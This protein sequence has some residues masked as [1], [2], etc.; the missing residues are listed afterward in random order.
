MTQTNSLGVIAEIRH[1][2]THAE[3]G[4]SAQASRVKSEGFIKGPLPLPWMR[5]AAA[6]PGKTMHVA[7]VLWYLVGLHKSQTVRLSKKEL[8]HMSISRDAKYDALKRLAQAGLVSI[9]Q[10][11]GQSPLVT[12]LNVKDDHS[13]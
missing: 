2:W 8:L 4:F 10:R 9:K 13:D 6:L 1:T 5:R 3:T 7:L 12:V 11:P